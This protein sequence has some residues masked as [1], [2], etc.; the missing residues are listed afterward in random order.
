MEVLNRVHL[1]THGVSAGPADTG[2]TSHALALSRTSADGTVRLHLMVNSWWEPLTFTLPPA[3]AT[4]GWRQW[5]DTSLPSP[6][7]IHLWTEAP[8]VPGS[9]YRVGPRSVAA[10]IA[11]TDAPVPPTA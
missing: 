4:S 8:P 11:I 6:E 1:E 3:G 10:V 2:Y 9:E 7:D 5:I